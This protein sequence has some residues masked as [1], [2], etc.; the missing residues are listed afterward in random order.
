MATSTQNVA[1]NETLSLWRHL[2]GI[3]DQPVTTFKVVLPR[4]KWSTWALPLMV[5]LLAFAINTVVQ[6]PFTLELARQQAENQLASLPTQQAEAARE[7]LEFTLSLPFMLATGLG[8]GAIFLVGG[9]VIQAAFFYFG[10]LIVG[11]AEV[12]YGLLFRL[13]SWARI[14]M[15][16]GYLVLAG[17]TAVSQSGI[18]YPGLA[19]LVTTGDPM[20]DAGN[21]LVPLLSSIDLF[22]LWHLLLIVMG[23]SVVA[24]LSWG[25][26]LVLTILYTALAL[27]LV[28]LPSLIFSG[29]F[30]G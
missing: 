20:K 3:I 19:F 18:Q 26:S 9:V 10:T 15:A 1:N 12:S 22:W 5:L 23:L 29:G 6:M 25:K 27:G 2:F 14:P 21:P 30:G 13:S 24:R 11:G 17:F 7:T 4:R 8:V 28:V 16:I